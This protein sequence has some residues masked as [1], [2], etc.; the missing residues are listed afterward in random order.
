MAST[1]GSRVERVRTPWCTTATGDAIR[2]FAW[3][4][5]D[6]NPL[7]HDPEY[8][9]RSRWG[10][11]IAPGCF[12]YAVD[13]TTIA[14]GH[15]TLRRVYN[16]VDWVWLDVIAVD[17]DLFATAELVAET[18]GPNGVEQLGR[19]EFRG[20]GGDLIATA[21]VECLRT[22]AQATPVDERPELRY[23][24][25]EIDAIEQAILEENRRG[26]VARHR[27]DVKV[28][29]LLPPLTKGPLSIM[30]VVAWCAAT[31]G[32]ASDDDGYSDGGLHAE[33][34]T[35]P[36]QTAWLGQLVTDWMGD[37]AFLHRLRIG[38]LDNPP[39]GSTT[40]LTG[41][42]VGVEMVGNASVAR[43]EVEAVDQSGERSASG[44]ATVVLPSTETGP[45]VLPLDGPLP[46]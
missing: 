14:P 37:D 41:R 38:V 1:T 34:A 24:G 17:T 18:E 25:A 28:G 21:E 32:V 35:G 23:S 26:A 33:T 19:V 39:L 31:Q 16:S 30:D 8:G 11:T 40:T 9:T 2:H 46:L 44:S 43:I 15:P 6:D 22:R 29:D 27:E 42:V 45:V 5:G 12:A 20:A 3:G 4:I 36:Q 10:A 7:W 13:E